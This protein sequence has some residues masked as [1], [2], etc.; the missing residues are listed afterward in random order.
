MIA[1]KV[2]TKTRIMCCQET[3]KRCH[4]EPFFVEYFTNS[5]LSMSGVCDGGCVCWWCCRTVLIDSITSIRASLLSTSSSLSSSLSVVVRCYVYLY[6]DYDVLNYNSNRQVVI[7]QC[8]IIIGLG[9]IIEVLMYVSGGG[10]DSRIASFYITLLITN[11]E[12][13]VNIHLSYS[14][15]LS[16]RGDN[17]GV[18]VCIWWWQ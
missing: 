5:G 18:N 10:S 16:R 9:V 15:H 4:F 6:I 8:I 13:Q 3:T 1:T 7:V 12:F 14:I 2:R 17:R 11:K